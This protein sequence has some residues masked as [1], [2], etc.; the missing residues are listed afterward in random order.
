MTHA[1][2]NFKTRALHLYYFSK[3]SLDWDKTG[4][5]NVNREVSKKMLVCGPNRVGLTYSRSHRRPGH[6]GVF[7][8]HVAVVVAVFTKRPCHTPNVGL[9]GRKCTA[10]GTCNNIAYFGIALT[11]YLSSLDVMSQLPI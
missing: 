2:L 5:A 10:A 9:G 7:G 3:P 6:G 11:L 4:G 8:F 1:K